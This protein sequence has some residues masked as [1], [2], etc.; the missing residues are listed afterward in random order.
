MVSLLRKPTLVSDLEQ[1][2][3][4]AAVWLTGKGRRTGFGG[5]LPSAGFFIGL[6]LL[7]GT[8]TL[9]SALRSGRGLVGEMVLR[10]VFGCFNVL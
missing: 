2:V 6:L 9:E 4:G 5:S 3:D 7:L 8:V 10:S 1:S